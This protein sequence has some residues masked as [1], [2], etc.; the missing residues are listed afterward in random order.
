MFFLFNIIIS[1]LVAYFAYGFARKYIMA[2]PNYSPKVRKVTPWVFAVLGYIAGTVLASFLYML[3]KA[4]IGL[5]IIAGIIAIIVIVV[6][7][8]RAARS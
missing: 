6:N 2:K 1:V 7:K 8:V 3:L 4:A 5:V